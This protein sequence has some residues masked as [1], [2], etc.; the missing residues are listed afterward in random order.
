M[1]GSVKVIKFTLLMSILFLALTYFTTVNIE[2]HILAFNTIWLSNNLALTVF[3]GAFASMLVVLVCELQ[4]YITAK[5]SV[6]EYIFYQALY[7]YQALFLMQQNICDYQKNGEADVPDNLLDETTRMVQSEIIALQSTD[8]APFG[9]KNSLL[10]A[11]QEFCKKIAIDMQP[12]MKGCNAV[13]IAI[14]KVKIDYLYQNLPNRVV[15]SVD[16]PLQTVLSIQFDRISEALDE[17][18]KYLKEIDRCCNKRY[19]WEGQRKR[20]RSSYVNI[21]EAWNFEKEYKKE[22]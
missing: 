6:E 20:I 13:K 11:H 1:R 16:E 3:G 12:I 17:V 14:N 2:A 18:D 10:I 7:L 5:T 8:Y 21:F 9:Q 15:T 4:K 19:D 22:T